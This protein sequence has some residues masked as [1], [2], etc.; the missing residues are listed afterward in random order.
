[1]N[2]ILYILRILIIIVSFIILIF[3]SFEDYKYRIVSNYWWI[4]LLAIGCFNIVLLNFSLYY[5]YGSFVQEIMLIIQPINIVLGLV[6]SYILY[7]S[8]LF[9][10]A[11]FKAAASITLIIPFTYDIPILNLG[12]IDI[13]FI[14]P[15]FSF[16]INLVILI[17]GYS[18]AIFIYN[19]VSAQFNFNLLFEGHENLGFLT[20]LKILFTSE[21]IK[22]DSRAKFYH[23]REYIKENKLIFNFSQKKS[24]YLNDDNE[25]SSADEYF[26]ELMKSNEDKKNKLK[27]YFQSNNFKRN[28]IWVNPIFPLII[29][30][31]FTLFIL[32][33]FGDIIFILRN[34]ILAII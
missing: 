30:M 33:F 20:K 27:G 29:F 15:V 10:G 2:L 1:M 9:G 13:I 23:L 17:F 14:F 32:I 25:P 24:N 26:F 4:I 6:L 5:N 31:T 16:Y 3:A 19:L 12:F 18:L 34:L 8:G 22:F 11:D 28:R 7:K 21:Y